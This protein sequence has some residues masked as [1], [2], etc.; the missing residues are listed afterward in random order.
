[1]LPAD[2]EDVKWLISFPFSSSWPMNWS[3]TFFY[4]CN[5]NKQF[6]LS[7]ALHVIGS[8]I[9]IQLVKPGAHW[10]KAGARLVSWN[11][12]CPRCEYACVCVSA[13]KLLIASGVIWCDIESLWLVKQVLGF[14]LSFIWQLKWR[15]HIVGGH[16]LCKQSASWKLHVRSKVR[17]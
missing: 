5:L 16:G 4:W 11:C 9:M 17:P 2:S 3:W 12:F 6:F 1:M 8:N 15:I 10:P 14:S 7:R 13:P